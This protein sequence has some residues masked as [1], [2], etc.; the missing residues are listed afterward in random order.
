[1]YYD[2]RDHPA[3]R[4]AR[5]YRDYARGTVDRGDIALV[6]PL[7]DLRGARDM[8]FQMERAAPARL[9]EVEQHARAVHDFGAERARLE[10]QRAR[11]AGPGVVARPPTSLHLP[12]HPRTAAEVGRAPTPPVHPPVDLL[13][14]PEPRPAAPAERP[15]PLPHP[16]DVIRPDFNRR[17]VPRAET[18]PPAAVT[19]PPVRPNPPAVGRPTPPVVRPNPPAPPVAHPPV[20]RPAPPPINGMPHPGHMAPVHPAPAPPAPKGKR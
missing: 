5:L 20:A 11:A 8:P 14:K 9:K 12:D 16:T 15:H 2:R 13:R 19:P 1:V 4:P 7:G 6:R 10:A 18:H 3:E 17:A